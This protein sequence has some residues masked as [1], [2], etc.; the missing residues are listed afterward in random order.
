MG[1]LG[2]F[3]GRFQPFHKG[4]LYSLRK[5]LEKVERIVVLVGSSQVERTRDNPF[6]YELRR[7][8]VECVLESEGL[9]RQVLGIEGLADFLESDERWGEE[10]KRLILPYK[11][12][13]VGWEE[14][15]V[16]GNNEWTNEVMGEAGLSVYES[17]LYRRGELEGVKIRKMMRSGQEEWKERVPECVCRLVEVEKGRV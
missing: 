9:G 11:S 17:G 14:V 2:V 6:S 7:R 3:I 13:G 12:E 5:A 15:L 8:M 1:K 10:V 16:V 4:H